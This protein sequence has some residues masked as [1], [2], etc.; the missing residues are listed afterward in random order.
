MY[1]ASICGT[2]YEVYAIGKTEEEC[3]KNLIKA[4]LHYVKSY[5]TTVEEWV[6]NIREDFGEYNNDVWTFLID[7][8]GVHMFDITKGYAL[9]W[10]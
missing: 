5:H 7:Y 4:F 3:K 8:Y 10:E 9:G 1:I 2:E 6:E